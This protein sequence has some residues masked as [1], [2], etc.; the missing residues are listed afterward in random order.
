VLEQATARS[1]IV[2]WDIRA[3]IK[4]CGLSLMPLV[5]LEL[6]VKTAFPDD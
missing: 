4:P 5:I 2:F 6:A 3:V 1:V